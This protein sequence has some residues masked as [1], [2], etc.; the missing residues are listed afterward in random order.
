M[1]AAT[2]AEGVTQLSNVAREPE[3]V[4][5]AE[6][7]NKMGAQVTGAG[8]DVIKIVGVD[9]LDGT[10]HDVIPDRI[11]AG[12]FLIAGAM[13]GKSLRINNIIPDHLKALFDAFDRLGVSYKR[14]ESAVEL[15][16]T[17]PYTSPCDITTLPYPGF[18]TDLQAQM[19]ALLAVQPV[20]SVVTEKIY[21]DRF[22][23]ASE[24]DRMG[25]KTVIDSGTAVITGQEALSGAEVMASDLRASAAL[26]LAGLVAE[27][28][29]TINRVYHLDRGYENMVGKLAAAGATITRKK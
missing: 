1:M 27:G 12:T 19:M 16:C 14:M 29:T 7:L 25:A 9:Q 4:D 10:D 22:M 2:R 26:I 28:T 5:L 23:H 8:T 11:E 17:G 18:P 20:T 3:I 15:S 24:L 6:F 21:P 13:C